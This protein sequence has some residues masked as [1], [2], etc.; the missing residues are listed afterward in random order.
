ME[1]EP[2]MTSSCPTNPRP[3]SLVEYAGKTYKL[4][5]YVGVGKVALRPPDGG[6]ETWVSVNE[7]R[8][9]PGYE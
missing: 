4:M 5:A 3:G 6:V 9:I 2:Q 1:D 7:I 8:R